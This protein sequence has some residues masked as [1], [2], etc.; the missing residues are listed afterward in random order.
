MRDEHA[1]AQVD[2]PLPSFDFREKG[3]PPALP[4]KC[5]VCLT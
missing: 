3:D 2:T 5:N 1:N 4:K